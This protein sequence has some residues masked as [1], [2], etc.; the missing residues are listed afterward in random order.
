MPFCPKCNAVY[1]EGASA[2]PSCGQPLPVAGESEP[3][4]QVYEASSA[5]WAD[6]V[7]AAL[8]KA[9]IPMTERVWEN[10]MSGA[11]TAQG[12]PL[13]SRIF[14][15]QSRVLDARWAISSALSLPGSQQAGQTQP[16]GIPEMPAR[17]NNSATILV[18]GILSIVFCPLLGPVA[19]VMGNND[20][21][22]MAAN[23]MNPSGRDTTKAGRICGI[24]GTAV[25]GFWLAYILFIVV[26]MGAF[27]SSGRFMPGH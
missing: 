13:Y 3:L 19:W 21:R 15:P 16:S 4:T 9:G 25:L 7:K 12:M 24:I 2:C 17:P 14:V 22:E 1:N 26:I 20:L 18:L 6:A 5:E 8:R 23:R 10:T 27:F 11:S